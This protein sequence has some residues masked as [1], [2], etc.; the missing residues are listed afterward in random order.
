M[1]LITGKQYQTKYGLLYYTGNTQSDYKCDVCRKQH[2][3]HKLQS[4]QTLYEFT[5]TN[6]DRFSYHYLI[7]TTCIKR[8]LNLSK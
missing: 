3:N 6:D 1:Q 2:Y 5:D 7:G 4:Y 8:F